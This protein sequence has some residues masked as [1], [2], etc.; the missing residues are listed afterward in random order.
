[1]SF[2]P[3]TFGDY[4]L[5]HRLAH[6]GMAEVYLARPKDIS[7]AKDRIVV[8][9]KILPE[10][11]TDPEFV[12]M[13]KQEV[14][15]SLGL[16]NSNIV[17]T[18]DYGLADGDYYLAM[19]Y[20]PG[21]TLS[22]LMHR[23]VEKNKKIP[24]E[25]SSY[26]CS[27]VC[28]ALA[29]THSFRDPFSGK[30]HSII[31][32]DI[33]PQNILLGQIGSVKLFDFGIAKI[34]D[35]KGVT[36]TGMIRGK[37]S[38]L[39]PEQASGKEL[40]GRSDLFT[41]GVVLWEALTG[42]R[43]FQFETQS[44]NVDKIMR[45]EIA[46]P[47]KLNRMVPRELD[48]IVMKALE[49]DRYQRY[50]LAQDLQRD[51]H[52]FL[53]QRFPGY[54]PANFAAFM[55][56]IFKSE[57][58]EEESQIRQLMNLAPDQLEGK[59]ATAR[60]KSIPELDFPEDA[61][62]LELGTIK[63]E[64]PRSSLVTPISL[65]TVSDVVAP[66]MATTEVSTPAAQADVRFKRLARQVR[67]PSLGKVAIPTKNV[68]KIGAALAL[69]IAINLYF[70]DTKAPKRNRSPASAKTTASEPLPEEASDST[71]ESLKLISNKPDFTL[72]LN[73]QPAK[74]NENRVWAP[75]GKPVQVR[76][77][78]LGYESI[79]W[80]WVPEISSTKDLNFLPQKDVGILFMTTTPGA[81]LRIYL[82][83]RLM[84]EGDSPIEHV[85]LPAGNYMVIIENDLLNHKSTMNIVVR[86]SRTTTITKSLN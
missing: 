38:Y 74:M 17:Q 65:K 30:H 8:I 58:E 32:R 44:I 40:D 67:S 57:F 18:Y 43:L 80:E 45:Q 48:R 53:Q 64:S 51:L 52:F 66:A 60:D 81:H 13:F 73:G 59:K 5:F 39:S 28:S 86:K 42:S 4:V 84:Y 49:R 24:V 10:S 36:K 9:K 19:E 70:G 82:G 85:S 79:E 46:P 56:E 16:S 78:L 21:H 34:E 55:Q 27:E 15:I 22:T 68:W 29:Y 75:K 41:V 63:S 33:S 7:L 1:M 25:H 37:I 71:Y 83:E 72:F 50:Q 35:S 11:S 61:S 12:T 31:H 54:G 6:G 26:I 47:S 76:A 2:R 69:I 62:P 3:V 14:S 77:D 20:V 23:I